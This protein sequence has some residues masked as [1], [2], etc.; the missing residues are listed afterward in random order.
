MYMS[1]NLVIGVFAM[2]TLPLFTPLTLMLMGC[3]ALKDDLFALSESTIWYCGPPLL[4]RISG[5][6][7]LL[8]WSLLCWKL[9]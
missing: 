1:Q 2:S 9:W 5:S 7:L 3:C 6:F 8:L 4:A